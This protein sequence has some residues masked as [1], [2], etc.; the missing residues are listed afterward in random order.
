MYAQTFAGIESIAEAKEL[1]AFD[2]FVLVVFT[3]AFTAARVV[4]S[5]D[6]ARSV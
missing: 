1:E 3:L 6:E 5:D 4:P 2:I